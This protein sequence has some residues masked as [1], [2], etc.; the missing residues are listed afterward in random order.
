MQRNKAIGLGLVIAGA[1][2]IGVTQF[3]KAGQAPAAEKTAV[4]QAAAKAVT[5]EAVDINEKQADTFAI[6]PIGIQTFNVQRS[7]IG[8]VDF[9]ENSTVQAFSNYQGKIT[10]TFADVGDR[11]KAGQTLYTIDSPD[12]ANAEST[13]LAAK[14]V[15]EL[16]TEAL[17]RAKDLYK[18]QGIAQ[19]DYEQAVSDQMTAEGNLK[20]ARLAVQVFGKSAQEVAHLEESRQVDASLVVKSPVSGLVTARNAQVGLLVQ[21]GNT[22]APFTVADTSTK[23]LI[24]NPPESDAPTF[25]VG[26]EIAVHVEALNKD[27]QARIKVVGQSLDPNTR[28]TTV[29]AEIADPKQEL[30]QGMYATYQVR[31]GAPVKALGLPHDAVAREVDGTMSVWVTTDKKHMVRRTVT[32]GREDAAHIEILSGVKEGELVANQGAIFLSNLLATANNPT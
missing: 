12:L 28:T 4:A 21:P 2:A 7:A 10:K 30:L 25:H 20:A 6:A 27:F 1:L 16:T 3:K 26:Q 15:Y 32:L 11:V 19:K 24:I 22:P 5:E 9:N 29:R 17:K 31:M 23:W 8:S 18:V 13:L 14:G